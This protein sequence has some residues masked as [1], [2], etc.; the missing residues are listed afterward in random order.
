MTDTF[1]ML[2]GAGAPFLRD[3]VDAMTIAPRTPAEK[4]G[5]TTQGGPETV[6]ARDLFAHLRFLEDG[7]E[8]LDFVLNRSPFREA[9]FL[10]AGRNFGCGSAREHSV[11][12]LCAFGIRAV[13][14]PSFGPLLYGNCFKNRVVPVALGE[15]EVK[16]LADECARPSAILT[17]DLEKRELIS[18]QGR[19][20]AFTLPEFRFRQ[21]IEGLDEIDMT[22]K[23]A[24][25]IADYQRRAQAAR[26]WLFSLP[27]A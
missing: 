8:I 19:R 5:A 7:S 9:K 11:W 4:G 13:I 18:P 12:A 15:D 22:L 2:T 20:I 25:E 6:M 3:N 17:L 10:I 26:P 1:P 16:R 27:R 23:R 21:L 14:A 24:D